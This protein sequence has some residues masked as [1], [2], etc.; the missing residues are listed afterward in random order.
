LSDYLENILQSVSEV[1]KDWS[2][3]FSGEFDYTEI[4]DLIS[5]L[6]ES[7]ESIITDP[8]SGSEKHK[9]V[10]EAFD[11]FD[12][13]YKLIDRLDDMIALPF[14]L[15]PFDGKLLEMSVDIIIT[16]TVVIFNKTIWKK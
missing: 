6:V 1:Q 13:K 12:A 11:Y 7:A 16:A 3:L 10:K 15:E 9:A 5:S 4:V 14:F 8:G 2:D